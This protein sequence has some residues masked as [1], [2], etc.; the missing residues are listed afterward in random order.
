MSD[1][2]QIA[3]INLLIL[4]L[5]M[6]LINVSSTGSERELGLLI[7]SSFAIVAHVAVNVLIAIVFFIKKKN[8]AKSYLLSA[9][10]VLVIGFSSCLGSTMI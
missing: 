10:I 8:S 1:I 6:V 5:Y 3:G 9:A 7:F 4:L 2:K